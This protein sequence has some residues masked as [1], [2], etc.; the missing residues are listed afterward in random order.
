MTSPHPP[1]RFSLG[2]PFPNTSCALQQ[3]GSLENYLSQVVSWVD[4]NPNE[5]L[6]LLFVNSD[7]LPATTWA[8]AFES[9]GLS[10]KVY[11]P[12]SGTLAKSSWPTLGQL[13][14]AGT[15]VVAFLASEADTSTVPYLL[16]EFT[17][18][19]ENA[20]DQTSVPFDCSVDRINSGTSPEGIMYLVNHFLDNETN[21]LGT[22]I[23]TPAVDQLLTTNSYESIKANVDNC[24]NLHASYPTFILVDFYDYGNGSVF[25]AAARMNGVSYTAKPIG[26]STHSSSSSSSSSSSHANPTLRGGTSS[27]LA[28]IPA[29]LVTSAFFLLL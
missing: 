2:S 13:I 1:S 6:T 4:S 18:M 14:D 16:P 29:G 22:T 5:V 23:Y 8:Q 27:L 15:T 7:G 10:K 24:A 20:Y 25:E 26:N 11:S 21:L 3:G 9:T 12:P 19:W 28:L 17:N